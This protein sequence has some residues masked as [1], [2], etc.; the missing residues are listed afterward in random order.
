MS[1][2]GRHCTLK[3]LYLYKKIVF[4]KNMHE[5]FKKVGGKAFILDGLRAEYNRLVLEYNKLADIKLKEIH[6]R[7]LRI[8]K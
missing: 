2:F 3:R 7:K 1:K 4:I 5:A 6:V 8:E